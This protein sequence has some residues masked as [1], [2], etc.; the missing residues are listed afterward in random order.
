[1]T[2]RPYQQE[3]L[4]ALDAHLRDHKDISPCV[5]IPTGGGKSYLIA[6]AITRWQAKHPGLRVC[7][8]QHRKELVRQNSDE[9][10][11]IA[12]DCDIGI[13]AAGLDRRDTEH[14]ILYASID[15]IYNKSGKLEPFNVII[16]DEA[17]RIPLKGEGKYRKFI[18]GCRRTNP[19][20][21]LVGFTATPFRMEG[22]I[23]H[24]DH[25]LQKMVYD[26]NVLDLINDGY[27]CKLRTRSSEFKPD[28]SHIRK[29]GGEYVVKALSDEL[30]T[31]EI[32]E[33]AVEELVKSIN[34]EGR[35]SVIVFAI[36]IEHCKHILLELKKH[37]INA[38]SVNAKTSHADR[39]RIV[40]DFKKGR[41]R[42]LVNINVYTEGFNAKQVD[43][44]ALLRP[45]LSKGLYVQMVG[46]GLRTHPSK[47]DCL[48]LDFSRCIEEH[49]PI[50]LLEE[51][52]IRMIICPECGDEFNYLIGKCPNDGCEWEIP[53]VEQK[54]LAESVE[55][56]RRMHEKEASENEILSQPKWLEVSAVKLHLSRKQGS[57]DTLRIQFRC[58][59]RSVSVKMRI[60]S[61]KTDAILNRKRWDKLMISP[62]ALNL[63][64]ALNDEELAERIK[65]RITHIQISDLGK[66]SKIEKYKL[67]YLT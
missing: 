3:A 9:L 27:L 34:A 23:C 46:R 67:N 24:K 25:M 13:Y 42:V 16:V 20:I 53:P 15:S 52:E 57:P 30:D 31:E 14:A 59:L 19:K 39:D 37:S 28:L 41:I 5:T 12:P 65:N 55:V 7:I 22:P 43:C 18:K 6:L 58:G 38:E 1:M 45:T 8:L 64:A 29:A 63:R 17:H 66:K 10:I 49:G 26:A 40:D 54:R 21:V 4:D 11:S 44:I 61:N 33:E 35:K 47:R 2:P 50:N 48:V 36:T 62:L 56:Q 32:V 60:P 51:Y